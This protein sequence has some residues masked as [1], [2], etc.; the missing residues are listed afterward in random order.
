MPAPPALSVPRTGVVACRRVIGRDNTH[1]ACATLG[2]APSHRSW[3]ARI[4]ESACRDPCNREDLGLPLPFCRSVGIFFEGRAVAVLS[5][6]KNE[7][8][9]T[10]HDPGKRK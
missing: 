3:I 9:P 1:L 7:P 5:Y 4:R 2:K 10:L 6:S 8:S